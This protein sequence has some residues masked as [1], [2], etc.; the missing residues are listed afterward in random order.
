MFEALRGGKRL[1]PLI[2]RR[3]HRR[4][5]GVRRSRLRRSLDPSPG[6]RRTRACRETKA[7]RAVPHHK[8]NPLTLIIA[9][10]QPGYNTL[11]SDCRISWGPP[12]LA[13]RQGENT[14]LKTGLL[15]PGCIFARVGSMAHSR[16]FI[17]AF[18]REVDGVADSLEGFWS[19]FRDFAARYPPPFA[20]D[21]QFQLVIS[22]RA[23]GEPR[24]ALW[25]SS[26]GLD[27]TEQPHDYMVFAFGSGRDLIS[28][29]LQA[30]FVPRLQALQQ[31][32]RAQGKDWKIIHLLSPY[33]LT[34][35]LSEL[36]LTAERFVLEANDVGGVF[37]F[38]IQTA[39]C[40]SPQHPAVYLLV[41]TNKTSRRANIWFYRV[42]HVQGGLYVDHLM[43]PGQES[44]DS[45]GIRRQEFNVDSA[46]R[47]NVEH[48]DEQRLQEAVK[49]ELDALPFFRFCGVGFAQPELRDYRAFRFAQHGTREEI[50]D[51]DGNLQPEWRAL[52]TDGLEPNPGNTDG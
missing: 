10:K 27:E 9:F 11:I 12:G 32:L 45:P 5:T 40:E 30:N 43:P 16:D 28:P 41:D 17:K 1:D 35:W 29:V 14:G 19:R 6:A 21:A 51:A 22:H 50:F 8:R 38:A 3:G 42:A 24:F 44:P 48:L 33:L 7:C 47:L 18:R 15:F 23:F 37:H 20:T 2:R 4:G 13:T 31:H 46:S 49:A 26:T 25:D 36:S 52:I 39:G 34:L